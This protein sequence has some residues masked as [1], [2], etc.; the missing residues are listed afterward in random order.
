[1]AS[2]FEIVIKADHTQ[3]VL[4]ALRSQKKKALFALGEA[5]E[6]N[7]KKETPV[8]TGRLKNSMSHQEDEDAT[9]CGT[10]VEY[11]PYQE[12]GTSRGIKAHHMIEHAAYNHN[13]EYLNIVKA[14]LSS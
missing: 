13:S 4:N 1:M 12:Y 5:C 9:Y 14:A 7:I 11:A 8:D 10:N 2:D 3:D 6:A